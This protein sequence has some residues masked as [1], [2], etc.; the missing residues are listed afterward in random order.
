MTKDNGDRELD[1]SDDEPSLGM[2]QKIPTP[3]DLETL[4]DRL[5]ARAVFLHMAKMGQDA[6]GE[7]EMVDRAW[8]WYVY[9]LRKLASD[10]KEVV[11][12]ILENRPLSYPV[13]LN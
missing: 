3:S 12:A 4:V 13:D 8:D 6:Y 11:F 1:T 7:G 10:V 2:N 5:E 9:D